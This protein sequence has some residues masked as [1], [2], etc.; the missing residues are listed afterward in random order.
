MTEQLWTIAKVATNEVLSPCFATDST[1]VHPKDRGW[2]WDAATQKA[3]KIS[4][5]PDQVLQTW[6]GSA[7]VDDAGKLEALLL[8][9]VKAESERRAMLVYTPN[10]GKMRE[11][12]KKAQ[13]VIDFRGLAGE[14]ALATLLNT[15]FASLPNAAKRRKFIYAQAD[16]ARRGDTVADA[17]A[18]FE[19][20]MTT[21]ET[22]VASLK[23]IEATA[24][25]A[26]RAA[27]S[28]AAKR[29]AY[30]A[31]DWSWTAP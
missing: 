7:W 16:A 31:V 30:A 29:A 19:A 14:G 9:S 3:T 5:Y 23:A 2:P 27:A 21:S 6:S 24:C 11:Y 13:E 4:A 20:G 22:T 15:L 8:T 12:S 10:R 1:G 26:I 17:I 28:A 25:A 18:R